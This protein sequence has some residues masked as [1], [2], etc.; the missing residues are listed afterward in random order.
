MSRNL[1]N[2]LIL[3][4]SILLFFAWWTSLNIGLSTDE[5]FHHINGLK[6][7]N[8]LVSL[9]ADK[10]FNFGNNELYPGLYDTL[11]YALGQLIL[12]SSN[13]FKVPSALIRKS[14]RGLSLA[15]S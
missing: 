1:K 7:Y 9:G 3:F 14:I 13:K 11:S 15:Q 12:V 6:R 5:Y 2:I 8:F 4:I 10:N